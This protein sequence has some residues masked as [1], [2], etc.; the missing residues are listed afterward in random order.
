M[1]CPY[2]G[3]EFEDRDALSEHSLYCDLNPEVQR[4]LADL[5]GL[6]YE[7]RG[8]YVRVTEVMPGEN[9]PVYVSVLSNDRLMGNDCWTQVLARFH[10]RSVMNRAFGKEKEYDSIAR[11]M[12]ENIGR[13]II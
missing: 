3:K 1:N 7:Y 6:T 13:T 9:R 10:Y 5:V 8:N 11:K 2:C 4:S 12:I